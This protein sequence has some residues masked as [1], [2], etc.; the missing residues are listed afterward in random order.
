MTIVNVFAL[1]YIGY[2]RGYSP[3]GIKIKL[4]L[5]YTGHKRKL[6][7]LFHTQPMKHTVDLAGRFKSSKYSPSIRLLDF[8]RTVLSKDFKLKMYRSFNFLPK[9]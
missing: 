5:L 4:Y 2:T 3:A 1:L 8:V 6:H 9:I 7:W